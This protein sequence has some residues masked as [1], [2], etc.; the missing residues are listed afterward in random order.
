MK[1]EKEQQHQQIEREQEQS[2]HQLHQPLQQHEQSSLSQPT[3]SQPTLSQPE[4]SQPKSLLSSQSL[5]SQTTPVRIEEYR[6]DKGTIVLCLDLYTL[7]YFFI[8]QEHHG[9]KMSIV[10]KDGDVVGTYHT[11]SNKE[12]ERLVKDLQE[13]RNTHN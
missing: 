12:L 10:F 6:N 11:P 4:S 5:L 9:L 13:T 7:K 3:L 1:E 2:L 8:T